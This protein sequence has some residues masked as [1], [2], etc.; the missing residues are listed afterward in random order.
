[1]HILHEVQFN[2]Y[3]IYY[4]LNYIIQFNYEMN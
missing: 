1:M 2:V 4:F 3:Y